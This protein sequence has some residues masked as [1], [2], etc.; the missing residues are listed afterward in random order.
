MPS[1]HTAQQQCH[2]HTET[3][4][5]RRFYVETTSRRRPDATR[6]PLPCHVPTGKVNL[7]Y[8]NQTGC[9]HENI[10][11]IHRL[12]PRCCFE[13]FTVAGA[14]SMPVE[15]NPYTPRGPI[16]SQWDL[17]RYPG[18]PRHICFS[19]LWCSKKVSIRIKGNWVSICGL[20]K[21]VTLICVHQWGNRKMYNTWQCLEISVKAAS[22]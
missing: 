9:I 19:Y 10:A 6:T 8:I 14:F 1:A 7:Q 13:P 22:H 11:M 16:E 18:Q 20:D 3:T 17:R 4:P 15:A 21:H 2:H 5:Q 12:V